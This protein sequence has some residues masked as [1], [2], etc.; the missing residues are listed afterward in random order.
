MN[1]IQ[2]FK[3]N[4]SIFLSYFI[5]TVIIFIPL[6][7][8]NIDITDLSQ[9]TKMLYLL[10][11]DLLFLLILVKLYLKD[12]MQDLKN[13]KE[14]F[15]DYLDEGMKCWIIGLAIMTITNILITHFTKVKIASNEQIIREIFPKAPIY[16][17][18]A[19]AIFAPIVEELIFRKSIRHLLSNKWLYII[20]SG[21]VFGS[22][23]VAGTMKSIYELLYIIP[24]GSL[25]AAFAYLYY[26]TNNILNPIIM[27]TIHNTC[28]VLILI[29]S[30]LK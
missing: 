27:H 21:L 29:F 13:F 11:S 8:L 25:G 14:N 7:I 2:Q 10:I 9:T 4:I 24:Y 19:T 20:M 23:H 28:L 17:F 22:L 1:N 30:Y 12:I 26:K 6:S 3:K 15:S 16:M 5:Y 18:F